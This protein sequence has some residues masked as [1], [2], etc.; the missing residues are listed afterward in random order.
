MGIIVKNKCSLK[1]IC[2]DLFKKQNYF[3]GV[4]FG[5]TSVSELILHVDQD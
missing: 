5:V 3:A 4:L 1:K 2:I